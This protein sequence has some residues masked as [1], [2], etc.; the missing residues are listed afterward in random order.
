MKTA[1]PVMYNLFPFLY[2]RRMEAAPYKSSNPNVIFFFQ[3][4]K[5]S[6][7]KSVLSTFMLIIPIFPPLAQNN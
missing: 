7:H 4:R 3:K 6:P 2:K 1:I 5:S